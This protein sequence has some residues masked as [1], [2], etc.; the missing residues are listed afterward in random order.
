MSAMPIDRRSVPSLEEIEVSLEKLKELRPKPVVFKKP[1]LTPTGRR[2]H[3]LKRLIANISDSDRDRKPKSND[4][5]T[6]TYASL[7]VLERAL[8]AA[9]RNIRATVLLTTSKFEWNGESWR[10][11]YVDRFRLC[12]ESPFRHHVGICGGFSGVL[13][14]PDLVAT[15]EHALGDELP[16][17][18]LDH[19]KIPKNRDAIPAL[20]PDQIIDVDKI[21]LRDSDRD[22][23]LVRL[24]QSPKNRAHVPLATKRAGEG[25]T[26]YMLG[27]P[28]GL[29]CHES[30]DA[31][32]RSSRD[33]WFHATLDSFDG[34]SGSPVFM[35]DGA[36]QALV[37]ILKGL[38]DKDKD[39][40]RVHP[41]DK[42]YDL[43][44]DKQCNCYRLKS[45]NGR[46][47]TERLDGVCVVHADMLVASI[48]NHRSNVTERSGV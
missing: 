14:A 48:E 40:I 6:G 13:V 30:D 11:A 33:R 41:D 46:G 19:F 31:I 42:G 35:D 20:A 7:Q 16:R 26:V 28:L 12:P 47:T 37:G 29:G 17:V 27:H 32:V 44:K 8:M 1:N 23:A 34:N 18:V 10:P 24:A 4:S 36:E 2:L 38:S 9:I 25:D 45:V 5:R 39:R 22:L 21:V 15:C 43:E 3:D